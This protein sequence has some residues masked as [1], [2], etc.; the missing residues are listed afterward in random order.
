MWV[1]QASSASSRA[2]E[3]LRLRQVR[4]ADP[5]PRHVEGSVVDP[6]SQGF[7]SF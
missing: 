3:K 4:V 6:D 5:E 2:V 1:F 7:A